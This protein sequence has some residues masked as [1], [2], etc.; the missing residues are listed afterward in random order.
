MAKA[1]ARVLV[2]FGGRS[3][4]HDV[5]VI[6]GIQAIG[7]LDP[8]RY[9]AIPLY[10]ATDGEWL[11]GDVLRDRSFLYARRRRT[12]KSHPRRSH[13]GAG[14]QPH[15][16][17][18]SKSFLSKGYTIPFDV[19]LFAFHGLVGEDGGLQ[20]FS[21]TANA[22][23]TGMRLLASAVTMDKTAMKRILG[24]T[25]VPVLPF[26]EIKRPQ[27]GLM[28]TP[29]ELK[30]LLADV[31][32]P[33]CIKPSHLGS[34]IGVARVNNF[35]EVADV[36]P[37]IFRFDDTAL[38]EPFVENLVEYNV[39]VMRVNGEI[40]TSSIER[41]KRTDELLDFKTK[42]MSGGGNKSER[43]Y[44]GTW[45][46]ECTGREQRRHAVPHA[47]NQPRYSRRRW[48][49][50]IRKWAT[51]VYAQIDGT[52]AP[53]LDFLCNGKTGEIWFNEANPCPGSFG[54][55]L[56]EA[57][58]KPMLFTALLDHLIAEALHLHRA[59]SNPPRPNARRCAIVSETGLIRP[60][61][62]A[63]TSPRH[64]LFFRLS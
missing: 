15:L 11:T 52:G 28:M 36:L 55:F 32:F 56:W 59:A 17:A 14:R 18:R 31:K 43:R 37:G 61:R 51:Q 5:S 6:T 50:N 12:G 44:Q 45:R 21:E 16:I 60:S 62:R 54:Y 20:G 8:E 33:C 38:L 10:I 27:Q 63:F 34:S 40:R 47:R 1:K 35:Q 58:K 42:Y 48:E 19:A 9:E 22:P 41:P 2:M 64:W 57:A 3:P 46:Q 24:G 7:A 49:N 25:D 53:R 23:Y 29:D 30:P 13:V 4:E 26:H 39:A